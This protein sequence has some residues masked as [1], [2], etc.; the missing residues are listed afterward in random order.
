MRCPACE[1]IIPDGCNCSVAD[2]DCFAI[3]GDG[4]VDTPLTV[5]PILDPDGANLLTCGDDGLLAELPAVIATPPA[6]AVFHSV[7]QS[8]PDDTDTILA[9][10]SERFDTDTMHDNATNNTRITFTTAGIYSVTFVCVWNKNAVGDRKAAIRKNGADVLGTDAK[11]AGDA[12]LFVGQSVTVQESFAAAD[13]V[14]ALV[15]QDS[16]GALN[17]LAQRDSPNF[18]AVFRRVAP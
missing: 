16:G 11:H 4:S 7:A 14:E 3:D 2:S 6:C 1:E 10:N 12:D 13:Y 17:L 8:I 5:S 18:A 15:R 9:F